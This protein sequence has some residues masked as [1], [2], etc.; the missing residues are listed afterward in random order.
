MTEIGRKQKILCFDNIE[1]MQR[2]VSAYLEKGWLVYKMSAQE[3]SYVLV[4]ETTTNTEY[5]Y[6]DDEYREDHGNRRFIVC[7]DDAY[8]EF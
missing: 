1:D 2:V 4:L 3:G 6:Y 5:E 8:G 7:D